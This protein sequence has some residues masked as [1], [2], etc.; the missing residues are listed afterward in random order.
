MKV[1]GFGPPG[2]VADVLPDVLGRAGHELVE[3]GPDIADQLM[4]VD[5]LVL[6]IPPVCV[7]WGMLDEMHSMLAILR[8][9]KLGQSVKHVVLISSVTSWAATDTRGLIG[10]DTLA[11]GGLTEDDYALRQ[12]MRGCAEGYHLEEQVLA[13]STPSLLATVVGAGLLYGAG[14]ESL[15][16]IFRDAWLQHG[17]IALPCYRDG[18]QR[19]PTCHVATMCALVCALLQSKQAPKPYVLAVE[20]SHIETESARERESE[21][22][23][24]DERSTSARSRAIVLQNTSPPQPEQSTLREITLALHAATDVPGGT[25]GTLTP[26]TIRPLG[27]EEYAEALVAEPALG[28]LS[29]DLTFNVASSALSAYAADG[30]VY[31]RP[32][33][34]V[35]GAAAVMAEFASARRLEPNRVWVLRPAGATKEMCRCARYLSRRYVLPLVDAR[36]AVEWAHAHAS[37]RLFGADGADLTAPAEAGGERIAPEAVDVQKM[38]PLARRLLLAKRQLAPLADPEAPWHEK[39]PRELALECVALRLKSCDAVARGYVLDGLPE[40][41]EQLKELF[42]IEAA[43]EGEAAAA[44]GGDAAAEEGR[45]LD[46]DLAPS[47]VIVVKVCAEGE[48]PSV[49]DGGAAFRALQARDWRWQPPAEGGGGEGVTASL[50]A[51]LSI[52]VCELRAREVGAKNTGPRLDPVSAE[53]VGWKQRARAAVED[54]YDSEIAPGH[55][56]LELSSEGLLPFVDDDDDGEP[57]DAGAAP[58]VVEVAPGATA[59]TTT[60]DVAAAAAEP[61]AGIKSARERRAAK[62]EHNEYDDMSSRSG[63]LRDY[64]MTHVMPVVTQGLLECIKTRP[65]DATD[66]MA[67]YLT[68]EAKKRVRAHEARHFLAFQASAAKLKELQ[69]EEDRLAE[70]EDAED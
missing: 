31:P 40:S 48:E 64:M 8:F 53:Q 59:A 35:A 32:D 2:L 43:P 60:D 26:P 4:Q 33:G 45:A 22:K 44:A 5:A 13:M 28:A 70:L 11:K 36:T 50:Q 63:L 18:S 23:Q 49:G 54:A 57:V 30:A 6:W 55:L 46:P 42:T 61:V 15:Y 9:G 62:A 17:E 67:D 69:D 14:E 24:H 10:G 51:L 56:S 12:P 20:A 7:D 27:A 25:F 47:T 37:P 65:E 58:V 34:L 66:F 21:S 41:P 3:V 29:L 39:V 19:I 38:A 1:L 16:P 52:D 68:V